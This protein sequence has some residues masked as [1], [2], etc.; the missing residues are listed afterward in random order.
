MIVGVGEGR[1]ENDVIIA[2]THLDG[3]WDQ[4]K[5]GYMLQQKLVPATA[6]NMILYALFTALASAA[7]LFVLAIHV[8]H[9]FW[10]DGFYLILLLGLGW[11]PLFVYCPKVVRLFLSSK[12]FW[13]IGVCLLAVIDLNRYSAHTHVHVV[14]PSTAASA[15]IEPA[16]ELA[17]AHDPY[18]VHLDQ[19]APVSPG[20][21]WILLLAPLTLAGGVALITPLCTCICCYVMSLYSRT[22]AGIFF[23]LLVVQPVLLSATMAGHDLFAIPVAFAALCLLAE[24]LVD[25][26][27]HLIIL[28]GVGG[29]LATSRLPMIVLLLIVG[30]GLYRLKPRSGSLFLSVSLSVACFLHI[31]FYL[32]TRHD[33]V[34]YQPL[35]LLH[36]AAV[37]S[38]YGMELLGIVS[39]MAVAAWILARMRGQAQDWIFA[40]GLFLIAA[41]VPI[42]FGELLTSH[43]NLAEWEG[44]NYVSFA[45]SLMAATLALDAAENRSTTSAAN[46][47]ARM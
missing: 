24:R 6:R 30:L 2:D 9:F 27:R 42:G 43:G 12:S 18:L 11:V 15:L 47:L 31:V 8:R 17:H 25:R 21:G 38:G 29:L 35:H 3:S 26:S 23:C 1:K 16:Q 44:S 41:F 37:H 28:A 22:G 46:R 19:G 10:I 36:R 40:G 14:H 5:R 13:I 20:P 45:L 39:A 32:W 7:T 34:P 33:G 4:F